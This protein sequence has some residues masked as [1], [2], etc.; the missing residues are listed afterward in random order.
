MD[1]DLTTWDVTQCGGGVSRLPVEG[2]S[3][4]GVS[5]Y[6]RRSEWR[7]LFAA[8]SNDQVS[9]VMPGV[10]KRSVFA[11]EEE[12]GNA[13]TRGGRAAARRARAAPAS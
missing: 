6:S 12:G 11:I 4:A 2:F 5:L 7:P 3:P 10:D 13:Q 1:E 8:R 9:S